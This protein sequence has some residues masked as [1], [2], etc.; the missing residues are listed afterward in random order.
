[1]KPKITHMPDRNYNAVTRYLSGFVLSGALTLGAFVLVYAYRSSNGELFAR[2]LL[3]G[4]L[5]IFAVIQ[6]V[7]QAVYFLHLSADR[8]IKWT[9]YSVIFS[10][11][12]ALVI[13]FGSMWV[14]HNLNYNMMPAPTT[15]YM[16]H[17]EGIIRP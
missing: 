4:V 16:V 17:D 6:I 15:D 7:V 11:V 5:G 13:V 10:V 14:M 1:M 12:I 9:R 2:G 3:F 8:R